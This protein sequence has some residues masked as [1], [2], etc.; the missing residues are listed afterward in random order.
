MLACAR[1]ALPFTASSTEC[2]RIPPMT[3]ATS[4]KA[5]MTAICCRGAVSGRLRPLSSR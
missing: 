2:S 1:A 3:A 5:A 4:T